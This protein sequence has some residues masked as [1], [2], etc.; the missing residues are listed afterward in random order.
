MP[1]VKCTVLN[2]RVEFAALASG[3]ISVGVDGW[4]VGNYVTTRRA[5]FEATE[6]VRMIEHSRERPSVTEETWQAV[7]ALEQWQ[8]AGG[9][10]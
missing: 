5:I 6:H 8:P 9:Q 3:T 7:E 10:P 1:S 2:H 4:L